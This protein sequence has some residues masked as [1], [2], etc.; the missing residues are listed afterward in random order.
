MFGMAYNTVYGMHVRSY[1]D[2]LYCALLSSIITQ[3]LLSLALNVLNFL[4]AH[5]NGTVTDDHEY[6]KVDLS[7]WIATFA[8]IYYL[9]QN[10]RKTII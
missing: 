5:K 8:N 9:L 7:S 1:A 6:G 2:K 10:N 3:F 4:N